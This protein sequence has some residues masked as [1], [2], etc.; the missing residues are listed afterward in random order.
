[1]VSS[2]GV[3]IFLAR[4]KFILT[5][6][7]NRGKRMIK[8]VCEVPKHI[9]CFPYDIYWCCCNFKRG[10]IENHDSLYNRVLAMLRIG[11]ASGLKYDVLKYHYIPYKFK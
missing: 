6:A 4:A 11:Y 10:Y 8:L 3:N 9:Y 1:M 7:K 2:R 5:R